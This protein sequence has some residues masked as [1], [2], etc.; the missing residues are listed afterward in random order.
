MKLERVVNDQLIIGNA[1]KQRPAYIREENRFKHLLVLGTKGSGKSEIVLPSFFKQDIENKRVGATV[2]VGDRETAMMMYSLAKRNNREVQLVKP[3]LTASG[4]LLL[5]NEHYDYRYVKENV[6]DFERAIRKKE[7]VIVDMEFDE[8]QEE[9]IRGTAFLLT[10]FREAYVKENESK[11][12]PHFL[13]VDNSHLYLPYV[14]PILFSGG[15]YTVGCTIFLESRNL[16]NDNEKAII[17]SFI[18]NKMFLTGLTVEDARYITED[19]YERELPY[20]LNRDYLECIYLT[21]DSKGKRANGV[22]KLNP[23]EK[24]LVESLRISVPRHRGNVLRNEV[25]PEPKVVSK[26]VEV[27]AKTSDVLPSVQVPT[28]PPLNEKNPSDQ[29]N[30][31]KRSEPKVVRSVKQEVKR[32]V[33]IL[34][35]LFGDDDEF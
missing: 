15:D 8:N 29:K 31:K 25:K 22:A 7:I 10:A 27:E 33:V 17:D 18:R 35:D 19:I 11:S 20:I 13:Y 14:L 21:L 5:E 34:D 24:E 2:F 23:L 32:H 30:K 28:V 4:M 3:S 16:L 26:P 1:D 9:A 12:T 6:I